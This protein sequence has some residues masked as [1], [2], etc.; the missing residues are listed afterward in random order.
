MPWITPVTDRGETAT[1]LPVDLNRISGN[2]NYLAG[3]S[4]PVNYTANDFLTYAQW[5]AIITETIACCNKFGIMYTQVPN[6][7]MTSTNFN[8]V[9][10]LL[11]QCYNR[12]LLWQKQASTNTYT[13]TGRY[14][15]VPA[16][17]YVRGFNY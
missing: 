16:N 12:L 6:Y 1:C 11:L 7:E 5:Q 2:I 13:G 10:D 15:A 14:T 3:T 4:L 17:N 8:N 9:E